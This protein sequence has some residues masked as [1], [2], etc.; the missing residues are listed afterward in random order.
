MLDVAG[1]TEST[2]E[3]RTYTSNFVDRERFCALLYS[4]LLCAP[5]LA[6]LS[7]GMGAIS[8]SDNAI[9]PLR[10]ASI[11]SHSTGPHLS[12]VSPAP[13][14]RRGQRNTSFIRGDDEC[15]MFCSH[16]VLCVRFVILLGFS[17]N[18]GTKQVSIQE[19]FVPNQAVEKQ[20]R[21]FQAILSRKLSACAWSPRCHVTSSWTRRRQRLRSRCTQRYKRA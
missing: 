3:R 6:S 2:Y 9:T 14:T 17:V 16:C 21:N 20:V 10:F 5:P 15:Y 11:E 19:L 13:L 18:R 8:S 7:V 12:D 4:C 1:T